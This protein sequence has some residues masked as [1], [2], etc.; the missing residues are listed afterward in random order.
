MD[1]Y[2]LFPVFLSVHKNEK[3]VDNFV[4]MIGLVEKFQRS[5]LAEKKYFK[6]VYKPL[7]RKTTRNCVSGL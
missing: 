3:V 6:N 7:V 4:L 5:P 2:A 1:G